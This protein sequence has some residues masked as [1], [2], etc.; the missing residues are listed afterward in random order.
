VDDKQH[1][2]QMTAE[3]RR[4]FQMRKAFFQPLL[5]VDA[6]KQLLKNQQAGK[7]CKLLV[8]ETYHWNFMEFCLNLCFTGL[9][10]NVA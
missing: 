4:H 7:G 8:F 6:L 2:N 10:L 3:D 5:Q 9:H 1:Y